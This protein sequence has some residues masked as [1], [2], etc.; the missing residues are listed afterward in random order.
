MLTDKQFS[1][2]EPYLPA[3]RRPGMGHREFL[4]AVL[5]IMTTG[6]Q[7]RKVPEVFGKWHT[8]YTRFNR[9]S[10]KGIMQKIIGGF[11]EAG[12][13]DCSIVMIDSTVIRAHQSAAGA[14]KKEETKDWEDQK[15]DSQRKFM[16]C[17]LMKQPL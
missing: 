12:I 7:W 4:N 3:K 9:W 11:I 17:L 10:E 16:Q 5:Y 6:C 1:F 13:V 14:Q 8:I 2:I 15:A